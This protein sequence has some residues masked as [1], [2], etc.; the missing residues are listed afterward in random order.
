MIDPI[1]DA[2]SHEEP[3]R[4]HHGIRRGHADLPGRSATPRQAGAVDQALSRLA[5]SGRLMRIC[6]GVCM[7]PIQTRFGLRAPSLEK[8]ARRPVGA[9]GRD[10]S[11]QA[12]ATR[13]T[14]LALR[15][16]TRFAR[17]TPGPNRL[18]HFGAHPVELR[19]ALAAGIPTRNGRSGHPRHRM[20]WS[21]A[22]GA[23]YCQ[24][25]FCVETCER[26]CHQGKTKG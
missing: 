22:G 6:R 4:A 1:S 8:S 23:F 13:P 2:E 14:G 11:F 18:L 26:N 19:T 21:R 25:T 10:P 3:A 17:S 15:H 24:L 9:L 5:R 12:A 16:G 7:R 20:A